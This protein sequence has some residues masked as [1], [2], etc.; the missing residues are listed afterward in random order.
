MEFHWETVRSDL[1]G[2]VGAAKAAERKGSRYVNFI[3][4][5]VVD[6]EEEEVGSGDRF[7]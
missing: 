2:E 7:I 3:M 6:C 5:D 1:V 4:V